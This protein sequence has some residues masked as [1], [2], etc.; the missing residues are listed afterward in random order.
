MKIK[1]DLQKAK[2]DGIRIG[3][4][5]VFKEFSDFIPICPFC[6]SEI[7]KGE[8]MNAVHIKCIKVIQ[9]KLQ[10]YKDENKK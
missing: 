9:N 3:R 10:E 1:E 6:K 4:K 7:K 8:G 2:K 5:Q